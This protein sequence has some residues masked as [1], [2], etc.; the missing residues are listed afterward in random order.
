MGAPHPLFQSIGNSGESLANPADNPSKIETNVPNCGASPSLLLLVVHDSCGVHN[1]NNQHPTICATHRS[2]VVPSDVPGF[3][4]RPLVPSM[5]RASKAQDIDRHAGYAYNNNNVVR[6]ER[7]LRI[8]YCS[9]LWHGS[10][11]CGSYG[12][13][14]RLFF[15]CCRSVFNG[16]TQCTLLLVGRKAL[17]CMDKDSND[18]MVR[19]AIVV[20]VVVIVVKRGR[21]PWDNYRRRR[22]RRKRCDPRNF[23]SAPH[24]RR[25]FGW[26]HGRFA[27][28]RSASSVRTG[29]SAGRFRC[30]IDHTVSKTGTERREG[31]CCHE[32]KNDR[33]SSPIL[34]RPIGDCFRVALFERLLGSP[35]PGIQQSTTISTGERST[36]IVGG[37]GITTS[38]T[39]RPIIRS[40]KSTPASASSIS[41]RSSG[42]SRYYGRTARKIERCHER[43]LWTGVAQAKGCRFRG[44][45][46]RIVAT[47]TS[48]Q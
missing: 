10:S 43:T 5:V 4:L 18:A 41:S 34:R 28:G 24:H 9:T 16:A 31:R 22:R 12:G 30:A 19:S 7:L 3:V 40:G 15:V 21:P 2:R 38:A 37:R 6:F 45:P 20:V 13:V 25:R 47:R 17:V 27:T 35:R 29:V 32:S 39:P 8:H 26:S 14:Q 36:G 42:S 23:G 48:R 11:D 1:S 46:K 33:E 44:S